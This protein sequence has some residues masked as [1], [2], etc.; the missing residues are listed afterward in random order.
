[1]QLSKSM[2]PVY[3]WFH[4]VPH[5]GSILFSVYTDSSRGRILEYT[6]NSAACFWK[7]VYNWSLAHALKP[8]SVLQDK[9][10]SCW[11]GPKQ[12]GAAVLQSCDLEQKMPPCENICYWITQSGAEHRV[13]DVTIWVAVP[14][15]P[16]SNLLSFIHSL[17]AIYAIIF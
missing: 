15:N 5:T 14:H 16:T 3:L 8:S 7:G 1:M 4:H 2:N 10:V 11:T 17:Y 6:D 12:Y 13:C 9:L